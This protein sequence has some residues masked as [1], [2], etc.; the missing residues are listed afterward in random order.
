VDDDERPVTGL[1]QEDFQLKEDGG[2]VPISTFAEVSPLESGDRPLRPSIVLLLD[3][4]GMGPTATPVVQYIAR[5]FV[6]RVT[7]YGSI[8][9]TVTVVR[10]CHRED[11]PLAGR[12]EAL[13]A[14]CRVSG[15][16]CVLTDTIDTTLKTLA[17]LTR[18]SSRRTRAEDR[19]RHRRPA[20]V[21]RR[22]DGTMRAALLGP[23]WVDAISAAGAERPACMSSIPPARAAGFA[24][25]LALSKRPAGCCTSRTIHSRRRP[26][27]GPGQ[28]LLRA[29]LYAS[30]PFPHAPPIDLTVKRPHMRVG[31]ARVRAAISCKSTDGGAASSAC[32]GQIARNY[33]LKLRIA[34]SFPFPNVLNDNA[35]LR[36]TLPTVRTATAAKVPGRAL[37]RSARLDF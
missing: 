5:A 21:R 12:A 11:E 28:S 4:T 26:H 27:L 20:C 6:T 13:E 2:R 1:R 19:C 7:V 24:T 31:P 30:R 14:H 33:A 37:H 9:P 8:E 34:G 32:S 10:L 16:S 35:S 29:R 36:S 25:A 22:A 18:R 23:A 17:S 3:D 15:G